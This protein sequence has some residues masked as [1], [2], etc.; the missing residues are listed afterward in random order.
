MTC[1]TVSDCNI[2]CGDKKSGKKYCEVTG[3]K[4]YIKFINSAKNPYFQDAT[5]TANVAPINELSYTDNNKSCYWENE[6]VDLQ[7][8]A[9]FDVTCLPTEKPP[10]APSPSSCG[11]GKIEAGEVC[12]D[13][14]NNGVV[15]APIT[16]APTCTYCAFGCQQVI[17][18]TKTKP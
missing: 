14:K 13:G 17:T 10:V 7:Y 8:F 12:D 11:N 9:T 16:N 2:K 4:K 6:D 18:K 1:S 3:E 5:T 15:C